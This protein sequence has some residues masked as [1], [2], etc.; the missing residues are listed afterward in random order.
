MD[1]SKTLKLFDPSDDFGTDG[2][3]EFPTTSK[4]INELTLNHRLLT[5]VSQLLGT[6]NIKMVQAD[7]WKKTGVIEQDTYGDYQNIDQ[8]IHMDYPNHTLVH[9]PLWSKHEAV[10]IIIYLSDCNIT[11]GSTA[12]IPKEN[13]KDPAYKWPYR[14]M[15]GFGKLRWMNNRQ[16]VEKYILEKDRKMYTFRQTL[17]SREKYVYFEPG[18]I[19]FYRYD[20][21]HR[22]TP[23]KTG[24]TRFVQN[25]A[26]IRDDAEWVG[27]WNRSPTYSMYR[28]KGNKNIFI[29]QLVEKLIAKISP[30]QRSIIGFPKI[31][32]K[33]WNQYTLEAVKQRYEPFGFDITPYQQAMKNPNIVS[34]L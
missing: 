23:L 2:L 1:A 31:G 6:K 24:K 28:C 27:N 21:W 9:P 26:F 11:A 20:T 18:T 12:I 5:A 29:D 30:W 8:R 34:K 13:E 10:E 3:L 16:S 19:L 4:F 17:Y 15:P 25:M 7:L 32:H 33:Y 14:N 22:G